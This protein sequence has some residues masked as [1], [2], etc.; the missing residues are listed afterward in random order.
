M[1]ASKFGISFLL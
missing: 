1:K